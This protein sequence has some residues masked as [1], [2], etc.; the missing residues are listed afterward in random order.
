MPKRWR[1]PYLLENLF[2]LLDRPS[3]ILHGQAI[4][5]PQL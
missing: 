5:V 1:Q 2:S 3:M 4:V